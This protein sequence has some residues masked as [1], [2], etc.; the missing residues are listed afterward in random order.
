R[1]DE[2]RVRGTIRALRHALTNYPLDATSWVDLARVHVLAGNH[3]A[4]RRAMLVA[5]DLAPTNRFAL[6]SA[7]RMYVHFGEP[8]VAHDILRRCPRTPEDPWLLG[9][10][11]AV[12]RAAARRSK[13][14]RR[15]QSLLQQ[16][17]MSAFS[18]SEL[19]GALG[20]NEVFDGSQR[21]ARRLF[22][23]A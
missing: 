13:L 16:H 20:T 3:H 2:E 5:T 12:A 21:I 22:K 9:A 17:N 6:R 7:A 1:L 11:I 8:D 23:I 4:A 14:I 19:A 10:E 15:G 18:L